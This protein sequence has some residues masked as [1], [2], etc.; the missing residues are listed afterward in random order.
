[1]ADPV[2]TQPA[3]GG[4]SLAACKDY[5]TYVWSNPLDME[6]AARGAQQSH[7]ILD[8][9]RPLQTN[10][11][12][13]FSFSA[14]LFSATT[15]GGNPFFLLLG[16]HI[17]GS[18]TPDFTRWGTNGPIDTSIYKILTM[19]LY[20]DTAA[21]IQI[22]WTKESRAVAYTAL[23]FTTPGWHTYS[24]DLSTVTVGDT[25]GSDYAWS[26]S[27]VI[28]LRV[29]PSRDV[30]GAQ[31]KI[32]WIQ[33]T[34]ASSDAACSDFNLS[35][36]ASSGEVV[37]LYVDDQGDTNPSNG[38]K[39]RSEPALSP[40]GAQS[41]ALNRYKFFPGTYSVYAISSKDYASHNLD[42]WDMAGAS[43]ISSTLNLTSPSFSG[44]SFSATA[45]AASEA[46]F[47]LN[48]PEAH[49][50]KASLFKR[51][52]LSMNRGGSGSQVMYIRFFNRYGG[53]EGTTTSFTV[54]GQHT[55]SYDLSGVGGWSGDI[56]DIRIDPS[57]VAGTSF[58]IDWVAL[59]TEVFGSEPITPT[60]VSADGN[61]EIQDRPVVT[62]I[63][64]DQEGGADYF[65]SVL[66]DPASMDGTSDIKQISGLSEASIYPGKVYSDSNSAVHSADYFQGTNES[67][68]GD[69][70]VFFNYYDKTHA[71]DPDTY[72]IACFTFDVLSSTELYHSVA[73]LIW[74]LNEEGKSGDDIISK[75]TGEARYCVRMD[76]IE[77]E[78][79]VAAGQPH[80]WRK[81]S[82]G[83]GITYFRFDPLEEATPLTFRIA[84]M[85]LAAD[86]KTDSR[87][88]LTVGGDRDTSVSLYATT[89]KTTTG[90]SL[91]TTIGA[92]RN[93]DVYLWD[94]SAL[95]AG[96]YYVYAATDYSR[97]LAPGRIVVNHSAGNQDSIA[98][99][100]NLDAPASSA[101]RF[102]SSLQIAG[103]ALDETRIANVEAFLD[104]S[105]IDS[106]TPD[107]FI[108][109]VRD[110]HTSYP[111][112]STAGFSRLVDLTSVP[113][114]D[115]TFRLDVY[116]TAGN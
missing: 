66:G 13:A 56:Y 24:I 59:G 94:T 22:S 87:F 88:A 101:Y 71:I 46:G 116:D 57:N 76:E 78:P 54:A 38:Y 5:F 80:P 74:L 70:A 62:M 82:D 15:T 60:V 75:T 49:P 105:L 6:Q 45:A 7:D 19:H 37:A 27:P 61:L 103:Y 3:G 77:T 111:Y 92:G 39:L 11:L 20:T 91:I 109:A 47:Y 2:I 36:T 97:A 42:P 44:G 93:S 29:D 98:P 43:D 1:M 96:T 34:P 72:K 31:V 48:I 58:S 95:A 53:L 81:N 69:P 21:D 14:G 65:T 110:S 4:L 63:S 89:T 55:Y 68:N 10:H 108:K 9:I 32:D 85:R 23:T 26:A 114:G 79:P 16:D 28:G 113:D 52:T 112:A 12:S 33:L 17:L 99:I 102:V 35:Y 67:G 115:H 90:G 100:F 30:T 41:I 83:T 107:K 104:G 51:L 64:P 25:S 50:V 8:D 73:R 84:D 18:L 106:F 40:G 86:H